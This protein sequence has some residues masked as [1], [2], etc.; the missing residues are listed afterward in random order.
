MSLEI[1]TYTLSEDTADE[2]RRISTATGFSQSEI[3]DCLLR[4]SLGMNIG[5]GRS[6]VLEYLKREKRKNSISSKS[7][8]KNNHV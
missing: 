1:K 7:S 3:A 5:K 4:M 2:I 6:I 8:H